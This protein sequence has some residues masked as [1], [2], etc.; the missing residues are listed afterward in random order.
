[1][2]FFHWLLDTSSYPPRWHC[3]Q[4]TSAMGWLHIIS[5]VAIFLAYFMIPCLLVFFIR[6]RRDVPMT[7][8]FWLF[9][10]FILSCGVG[11]LIEAGIFWFPA[12]RL[13][14]LVK[15]MTAVVSLATVVVLAKLIPLALTIPGIAKLN[16]QLA[17]EIEERKRTEEALQLSLAEVAS[18]RAELEERNITLALLNEQ[19]Q[20]ASAAAETAT[21]S[22]SEFLANMSHEIRT[23]M[24]AILGYAELLGHQSASAECSDAVN[25]IRRN[26]QHLLE[27]INDILDLS[28]IEAGRLDVERIDCCPLQVVADVASLMRVRADAKN[29][30]LK[31]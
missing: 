7:P 12:Y 6:K 28:K 8:V 14:G 18:A 17:Q 21:R 27:I 4:W 16:V 29:L 13:A 19:L 5:D 31:V 22:K 10:A 20:A 25:T 15:L 23:P 30:Q 9:A 11:H 2:D 24:T 1:M 3:G 26:G